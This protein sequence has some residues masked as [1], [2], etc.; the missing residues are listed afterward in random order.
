MAP[1]D[2]TLEISVL[3]RGRPAYLTQCIPGGM[4]FAEAVHQKCRVRE[5]APRE[6]ARWRRKSFHEGGKEGRTRTHTTHKDT[7]G[8][9][10]AHGRTD[11][12]RH[13]RSPDAHTDA[14][15][16]ILE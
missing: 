5:R 15:T 14:H 12:H 6:R 16:V 1:A 10:D 11:V 9:A 13:I 8:T 2:E 7:H 4:R 3:A